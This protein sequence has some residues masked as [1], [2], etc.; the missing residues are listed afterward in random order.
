MIKVKDYPC[1]DKLEALKRERYWYE[2]LNAD[3]NA[4]LP[5]ITK[6]ELKEHM[7]EY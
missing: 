3:L 2:V 7:K 5:C 6:E 4:M 1:S